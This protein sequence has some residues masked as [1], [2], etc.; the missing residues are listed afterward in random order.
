MGLTV[1]GPLDRR[2]DDLSIG[3]PLSMY[4]CAAVAL[5]PTSYESMRLQDAWPLHIPY[6]YGLPGELYSHTTAAELLVCED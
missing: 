4:G 2:I 1:K 6:R 3:S 5:T